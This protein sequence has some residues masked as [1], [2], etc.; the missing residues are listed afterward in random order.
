[1]RAGLLGTGPRLWTALLRL[2]APSLTDAWALPLARANQALLGSFQEFDSLFVSALLHKQQSQ[3]QQGIWDQV[4][5]I[6]NLLFAVGKKRTWL[7]GSPLKRPSGFSQVF[8]KW[9]DP[10]HAF[11]WGFQLWILIL[12]GSHYQ[13]LGRF[14]IHSRA[15]QTSAPGTQLP[16]NLWLMSYPWPL[17]SQSPTLFFLVELLYWECPVFNLAPLTYPPCYPRTILLKPRS[18]LLGILPYSLLST[19]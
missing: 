17:P 19:G 4:V 18:A 13:A 9:E 11:K 5:V 1:M 7:T 15:F 2:P 10:T 6:F 12:K 3:L 16:N 14:R 8:P